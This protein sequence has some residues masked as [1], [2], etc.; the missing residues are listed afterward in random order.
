MAARGVDTALVTDRPYRRAKS[1]DEAM[2]IL[3][4]GA[5]HQWDPEAVEVLTS[6]MSNMRTLGVA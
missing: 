1:V 4:D 5:G 6:E 2:A 3:N